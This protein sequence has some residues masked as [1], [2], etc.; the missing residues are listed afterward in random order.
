MKLTVNQKFIKICFG[1]ATLQ[2]T[3]KFLKTVVKRLLFGHS[4]ATNAFCAN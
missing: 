4:S 2:E 1:G 3:S